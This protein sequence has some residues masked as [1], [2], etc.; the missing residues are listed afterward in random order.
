MKQLTTTGTAKYVSKIIKILMAL[1]ADGSIDQ[2]IEQGVV[3]QVELSG[4]VN[5]IWNRA[6]DV[7]YTDDKKIAI[8]FEDKKN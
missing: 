2:I 5:E 4:V 3:L 8:V 1:K 7:G 6:Y